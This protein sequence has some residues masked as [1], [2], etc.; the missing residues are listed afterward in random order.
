VGGE[1]TAVLARTLREGGVLLAVADGASDDVKRKV[2]VL[3]PLVEP[4]GHGLEQI[5]RLI[6]CGDLDVQVEEVF[7]LE[8]AAAAHERLERGGTKGKLV[9]EVARR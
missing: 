7:P 4:D 3:E 2:R 1:D 9:L 8:H 5:A 6:E